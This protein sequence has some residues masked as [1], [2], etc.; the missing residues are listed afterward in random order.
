MLLMEVNTDTTGRDLA[1]LAGVALSAFGRDEVSDDDTVLMVGPTWTDKV[2][3]AAV[4][5]A[6]ELRR[7]C[8]PGSGE[9]DAVAH[10]PEGSSIPDYSTEAA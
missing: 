8:G 2:R 3:R 5:K 7:Q 6:G 10:S 4:F 1:H 9:R